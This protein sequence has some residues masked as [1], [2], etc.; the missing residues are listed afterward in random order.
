MQDLADVRRAS[1][2]PPS[3]T[4]RFNGADAV[5]LAVSMRRGGDVI[6]LGARLTG[7]V[8]ALTEAE[9]TRARRM[10]HGPSMA[11]EGVNQAD[12]DKLF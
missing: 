3:A 9:Q 7:A 4:M 10:M 11:G 12:I 6:R 1:S 5:G 2:D 8:A